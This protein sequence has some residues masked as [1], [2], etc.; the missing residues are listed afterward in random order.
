MF[1]YLQHVAIYLRARTGT[2]RTDEQGA[3]LI[4]Y[5]I[6]VSL[7][8]VAAVYVVTQIIN[9]INVAQNRISTGG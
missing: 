7:V 3:S 1:A 6:V 9:K 5:V 4:E 2:L 8:S